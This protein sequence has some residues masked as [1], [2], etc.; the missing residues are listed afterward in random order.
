M[1]H[2]STRALY[3]YWNDRRGSQ[4]APERTD[5]DPTA[6]PRILADTF[7]LGSS[8]FGDPF[9]RLAGTRVCALFCR[10][11]K[12]QSF[13]DLFQRTGQRPIRAVLGL[14][15]DES[16]AT[17]AGVTGALA[18]GATAELELL[19]LPLRHRGRTDTRMLGVIAPLTTPY[20]LG[21]MPV[22]A[23]ALG[24]TRNIGPVTQ[25]PRS[26]RASP[27]LPIAR[28]RHGLMVYDGGRN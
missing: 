28:L 9:F 6:I 13:V 7:L 17:V 12:D 5:I 2:P 21:L 15:S 25:A 26:R 1:K 22:E 3:E 18:D 19:L 8:T 4:A 16:I 23:L 27:V 10:E 20:W 14:V 11:L 24:V